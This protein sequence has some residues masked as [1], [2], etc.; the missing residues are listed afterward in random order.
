[1]QFKNLTKKKVIFE[2]IFAFFLIF[3]LFYQATIP[4]TM[5]QI[6]ESPLGIISLLSIS[7]LLFLYCNIFLA[8]LF[9]IVVYELIRRSSNITGRRPDNIQFTPT[10]KNTDNY[11]MNMNEQRIMTL[12]EDVVSQMAPISQPQY[13]E[14]TFKPVSSNDHNALRI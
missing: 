8:L 1:M 2:I 14:S 12:E 7:L 4:D 11:M 5:A 13:I 3:F 6:I 9:L 10:H